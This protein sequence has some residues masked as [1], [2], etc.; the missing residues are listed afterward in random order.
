MRRSA[1]ILA[2]ALLSL[3]T[4]VAH[5]QHS[6]TA[7]VDTDKPGVGQR[8]NYS[9]TL[10]TQ[11]SASVDVVSGPR[12]PSDV[13]V[14][15]RQTNQRI[16]NG[17]S[18]TIVLTLRANKQG[19]FEIEPP[20]FR[21]GDEK[22]RGNSVQVE[23]VADDRAVTPQPKK[24]SQ[25][26]IEPALSP[27]GDVY[28]GEQ[29]Q[30]VYYLYIERNMMGVKSRPPTEP[31]LDDFW[32]E[33]IDPKRLG[34]TQ[35][36]NVQGRVMQRTPLRAYALFP[37]K[38]G[39][40][41]IDSMSVT[42][43]VGGF[44]RRGR[45][46]EASSEKLTIEAKPLPAD[47]PEGF[48]SGNVG[49]WDFNARL[50]S[51][52]TRVGRPV[53]LTLVA[54]GEGQVNRLRLPEPTLENA[55][56]SDPQ[57]EVE[58]SSSSQTVRGLKRIT[59]TIIPTREGTLEIPELTFAWF[60]PEAAEYRTEK[61]GPMKIEVAPGD[62][63]APSIE[64]QQLI[65]RK[66]SS[67]D[68]LVAELKSRL[69]DPR[70]SPS[71]RAPLGSPAKNPLYWIVMGL[72]GL[73][74]IFILAEPYLRKWRATRK[75]DREKARH[76]EEALKVLDEVRDADDLA[77][78]LNLYFQKVVELRAGQVSS[79]RIDDAL[80]GTSAESNTEI[81]VRA[82]EHCENSRFSPDQN[83]GDTEAARLGAECAK[84]IRA[85]EERPKPP[86]KSASAA[87]FVLI[88]MISASANASDTVVKSALESHDNG[89]YQ[90][91]A[92]A[93]QSLLEDHQ[94]SVDL[95]YNEGLAHA[96]AGDLASAR[97]ALERATFLAP[98][99]DE[100]E[101]ARARVERIIRL[102]TIQ[103][104]RMGR[105]LE[106]TEALF[107]WRAAR[108]IPAWFLP[109]LTLGFLVALALLLGLTRQ[110]GRRP[111]RGLSILTALA[112]VTVSI[113]W[114]GRATAI[115]MVDPVVLI[116]ESPDFRDGPSDHASLQQRV[117]NAHA[118]TVF[119]ALEWRERWVKLHIADDR[120][121]W[122]DV[123][124]IKAVEPGVGP[125]AQ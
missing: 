6:V 24:S 88:L 87:L 47:A 3:F 119:R 124:S 60:D 100:I 91:A 96:R 50:D 97:H 1:Q 49:D 71:L 70:P 108:R 99:D 16:G 112:L 2:F 18:T 118:G 39:T 73:A 55:R 75:P 42:L 89:E 111:W 10:S 40:L 85:L 83:G 80:G 109:Y 48:Y 9:V 121:G 23:V 58:K 43:S 64:P 11:S 29:L 26:F 63:D 90:A 34:G 105:T 45:E 77:S 103:E 94:Y 51:R 66:S 25:F 123:Q 82:L 120:S 95:L 54:R 113:V 116:D 69:P 21:V 57:E 13:Q 68:D 76:A 93:W 104:S 74:C 8:F 67:T 20:V 122:L 30:L 56:V 36:V 41:E 117:P 7:S 59:Y 28:V 106:G 114:L 79:S 19:K 78:G 37:L 53:T 115:D 86:R 12:M 35:T 61:A 5:A 44:F 17:R 102:E 14:V 33:D 52:R 110:Y 22:V 32:I 15:G 65:E 92:T 125:T 62:P 31:A 38:A 98:L 46:F 27:Q 101:S 107:W 81:F 4:A 72:L 84:A